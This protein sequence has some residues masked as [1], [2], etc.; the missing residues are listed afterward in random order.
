VAS[1]A[2]ERRNQIAR[3]LGYR[4]YYARRIAEGQGRGHGYDDLRSALR[5]PQTASVTPVA[6]RDSEGRYTRVTFVVVDAEG[7][8]RVFSMRG[9][10]TDAKLR[11]I[12][13]DLRARVVPVLPGYETGGKRS[14][15]LGH[16]GRR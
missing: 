13:D 6:V 9:K 5:N 14:G 15:P 16:V 1:A 11:R 3:S 8:E 12:A 2:Q 7:R 10:I 4:N